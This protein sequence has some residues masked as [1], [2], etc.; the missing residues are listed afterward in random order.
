MILKVLI[1]KSVDNAL[2]VGPSGMG[3]AP[4][5]NQGRTGVSY[6]R[7]LLPVLKAYMDANNHTTPLDL[8]EFKPYITM[9]E[10]KAAFDKFIKAATE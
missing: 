10:Q 6:P 7:E 2:I 9:S 5:A 1:D 8:D 3:F 4:R